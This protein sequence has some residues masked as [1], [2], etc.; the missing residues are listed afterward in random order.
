MTILLCGLHRTC[1]EYT[2][3]YSVQMSLTMFS[4]FGFVA[5][6]LARTE[7]FKLYEEV[8]QL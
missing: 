2:I 8:E 4:K 7:A 1:T 3:T 5:D 6:I